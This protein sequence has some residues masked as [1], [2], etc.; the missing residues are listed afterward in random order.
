MCQGRP[1]CTQYKSTSIELNVL[2]DRT[3][4]SVQST[5]LGNVLEFCFA[6]E[7]SKIYMSVF[8]EELILFYT[9][10]CVFYRTNL[11]IKEIFTY[12]LFY[13]KTIFFIAYRKLF[14]NIISFYSFPS[15]YIEFEPKK[16][17]LAQNPLKVSFL[18]VAYLSVSIEAF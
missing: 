6:F 3:C 16:T 12:I 11:S 14:S 15:T 1:A 2:I 8:D 9:F 13:Y 18:L 5:E 4:D 17:I 7:C 10:C